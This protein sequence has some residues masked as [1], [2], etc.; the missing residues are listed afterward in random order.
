MKTTNHI[1]FIGSGKV[2]TQLAL[3]L[4]TKGATIS[5]IYSR[6]REHAENLALQVNAAVADTLD[7]FWPST[8]LI[9]VAVSD[10]A[11][12]LIDWNCIPKNI[13]LCHTS[14]SMAM[15]VFQNRSEYGVLYPLQT[16][17]LQ[18]AVDFSQIPIGI[19]ANSEYS[20]NKIKA[21]SQTISNNV[22]LIDSQKRMTLH[23][24]AVFASNFTNAMFAIAE[25]LLQNSDLSFDL[26]KPLILETTQKA[27]LFSPKEVQTG[28]AIRNDLNIINQHLETLKQDLRKLEI[29]KMMTLYIRNQLIK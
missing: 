29:Y 21:L 3:A 18:R 27:L 28:P 11:L 26:L 15:N 9:I 6:K 13:L 17:S 24:S 20:L 16:I 14:G 10:S 23:L 8:E 7:Q 2:A 19:E 4:F 1:G 5:Q 12:D 25:D 22:L